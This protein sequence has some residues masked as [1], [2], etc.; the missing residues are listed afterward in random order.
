MTDQGS[1]FREFQLQIA[2]MRI[3]F[4]Q[5]LQ[6][7]LK[8]HGISVT[9][10]MLQVLSSLWREPGSTQQLLAERTARSKA[11]LSSLMTTLEKRGWIWL[12]YTSDAADGGLGGGRGGPRARS[13]QPRQR[14]N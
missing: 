11:S 4:R 3:A 9:F 8:R 13:A 7:T 12:L 1:Q 2:W 10:E 5:C 14:Q 6:R